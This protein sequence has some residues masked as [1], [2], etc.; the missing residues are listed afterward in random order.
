[1][2]AL[3]LTI[4]RNTSLEQAK[5]NLETY[6]NLVARQYINPNEAVKNTPSNIRVTIIDKNGNVLADSL[7]NDVSNMDNHLDRDEVQ[8]A[9]N[10]NPEVFSRKSTVV[11]QSM[12][13]YAIKQ[14]IDDDFVIVR[15]SI[16]EKTLSK[17]LGKAS[18]LTAILA[19]S[20]FTATTIAAIFISSNTLKPLETVKDQL[21]AI[22]RGEY[23]EIETKSHDG[24]ISLILAEINVIGQKLK[25]N[26]KD[27]KEGNE[28][29]E[30]IVDNV[31]DALVVFNE[32]KKIEIINREALSIF[33]LTR[34]AVGREYTSLGAPL[35]FLKFI[36]EFISSEEKEDSISFEYSINSRYYSCTLQRVPRDFIILVMFD[37]TY[38]KNSEITRSE[39]FANAS[40]ELKTP[41]TSI[42]GFAQMLD[43]QKQKDPMTEKC[44]SQIIKESDKMLGLIEDMLSLSH[45][46]TKEKPGTEKIMLS[47]IVKEVS[48]SL[49]TISVENDVK[50][51]TEGEA[52]VYADKAHMYELI[53]NLVENSIR[54][55]SKG[56]FVKVSL[57]SNRN[58]RQIVVSDNGIGIAPKHQLRIFE[59]FYRVNK[60]RSRETG[61][62][63]LGLAIV[64]HV[65]DLYGGKIKLESRE[66]EGTTITIDL[67]FR[68][69]EIAGSN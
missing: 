30:H 66:G 52:I 48:S 14:P 13:Y 40:H 61:G 23:T 1:M 26:I 62:T 32:N 4:V 69:I 20:I 27:L 54:Y 18:F 24:N 35:E 60:S 55:N 37:L 36:D 12:L 42:S 45:I 57:K 49:A 58:K 5:S 16:T 2:F 39:F 59:R 56:G 9:L 43:M 63:G 21:L 19:A 64:K 17:Y 31:S 68:Q 15:A 25:D 46:E 29:L 10:D 8:A 44:V 67:P 38:K 41:L 50:I 33:N 11:G 51:E 53:K 28:K 47:E 22:N 65:V 3:N 34:Q 6:T 7:N